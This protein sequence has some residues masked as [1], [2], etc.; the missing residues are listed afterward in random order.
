MSERPEGARPPA[1]SGSELPDYAQAPEWLTVLRR[2]RRHR[3]A[4]AS[5]VVLLIVVACAAGAGVIA[6]HGATEQH[7]DRILEPPSRDFLLGSDTLG[8]DNLSRILYG[9]RISLLVGGA[10]ALMSGV[11]G[12]SVG[13]VA[14]YYG[15]WVDAVLMRLA[16]T[17]LALPGLMVVII[18]ARILGDG[19][20]DVVI[21]LAGITWMIPARIVRGK[22]LALK[23]REF[24]EAARALGVPNRRIIVRHLLPNLAG[25]VMVSVSLT[26]AAAILAESTL[27]F[28]GLG[29]SAT[30][31]ATWGNMLGGN[32]GFVII[33]PWLVWAPG[34]AI[35]VTALCV[36]FVGDGLRDSLDP[37]QDHR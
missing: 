16:D 31:T 7:L 22:V 12:T 2:F 23:E 18:A 26:V 36:N 3:A 29:V 15:R 4:M 11:I 6:P 27:S 21:V 17:M 1:L 25:E 9:G 10:V 5:A 20:W 32:E 8:R 24:V 35:V 34:L 19:V 28:L 33:A 30:R 14:G 37:T 13:L